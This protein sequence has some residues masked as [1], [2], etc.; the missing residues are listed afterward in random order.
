[1][2]T[3]YSKNKILKIANV[4]TKAIFIIGQCFSVQI[5]KYNAQETNLFDRSYCFVISQQFIANIAMLCSNIAPQV[6]NK[7][8]IYDFRHP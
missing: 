5:F 6:R 4:S 3:S 2:T 7:T 1:M 8:T